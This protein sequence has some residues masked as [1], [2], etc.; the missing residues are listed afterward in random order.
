MTFAEKLHS[1][2]AQDELKDAISWTPNGRAFRILNPKLLEER[3]VLRRYFGL[4]TGR[5]SEFVGEMQSHGLQ[6]AKHGE[7]KGAYYHEV[8]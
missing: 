3:Q 8:S 1:I 2:L 4:K 7:D 6:Q 5:Y